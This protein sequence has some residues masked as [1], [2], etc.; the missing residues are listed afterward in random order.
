MRSENL[1]S[2][3]P[4]RQG[5]I[6]QADRDGMSGNNMSIEVGEVSFITHNI[7]RANAVQRLDLIFRLV[8][9]VSKA[10]RKVQPR[11]VWVAS[12]EVERVRDQGRSSRIS[13]KQA[14]GA[15]NHDDVPIH[16]RR[17]YGLTGVDSPQWLWVAVPEVPENNRLVLSDVF[18]RHG[19]KLRFCC[20]RVRLGLAQ[21]AVDVGL[22]DVIRKTM[23]VN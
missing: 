10:E 6:N 22:K 2:K 8:K 20:R 23:V 4:V 19:S 13:Y 15:A 5:R 18:R 16:G 11:L 9:K 14:L 12:H 21:N 17:P 1:E 3:W 7:E